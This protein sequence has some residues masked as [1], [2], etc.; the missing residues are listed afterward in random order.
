MN[1]RK[2]I[3]SL[4][5]IPAIAGIAANLSQPE[6]IEKPYA[7]ATVMLDDGIVRPMYYNELTRT[8]YVDKMECGKIYRYYSGPLTSR[9]II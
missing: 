2:L 9:E 7:S 8:F 1:R 5:A 6:I 4:I 3:K